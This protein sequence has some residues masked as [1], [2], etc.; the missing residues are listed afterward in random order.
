[1]CWIDSVSGRGLTPKLQLGD[2]H[3]LFFSSLIYGEAGIQLLS[4]GLE[5]FVCFRCRTTKISQATINR[6]QQQ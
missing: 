5:N 1:M 6:Y 4:T 2:H 3:E